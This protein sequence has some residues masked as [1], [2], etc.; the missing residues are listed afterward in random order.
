VIGG[1]GSMKG[2]LFGAVIVGFMRALALTFFPE[3][4]IMAIYIVV[5]AVL[6]VRPYGVFG[7]AMP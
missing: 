3:I 2:A 4:E 7:R 6:L 5:V 1:L